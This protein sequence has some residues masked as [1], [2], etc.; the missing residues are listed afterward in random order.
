MQYWDASAIVPL[1]VEEERSA[2]LRSAFAE[3]IHVVTWWGT[4]IECT[5]AISRLERGGALDA[6]AGKNAMLN[7]HVLAGSWHEILPGAAMR[8]LACD[9][10]RKHSLRA[11]DALQLAAA[12]L[13]A[14]HRPVHFGFLSLDN[15][16]RAAAENEGFRVGP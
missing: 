5:S 13:N 1:L 10:L 2:T 15:R 14:D 12:C 9:L 16:L 6:T 11:A 7:L 8:M 4:L 3:D